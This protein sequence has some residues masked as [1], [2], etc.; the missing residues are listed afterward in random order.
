[1]R[2]QFATKHK[3]PTTHIQAVRILYGAPDRHTIQENEQNPRK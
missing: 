3:T 2:R 1:M